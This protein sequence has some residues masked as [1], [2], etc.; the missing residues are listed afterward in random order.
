MI[1][2]KKYNEALLNQCNNCSEKVN[3]LL[4]LNLQ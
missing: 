3:F 1:L 4:K 2:S